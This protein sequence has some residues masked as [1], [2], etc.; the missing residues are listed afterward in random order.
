MVEDV[1][2]VGGGIAGLTAAAYLSQAGKKPLLLEKQDSCGGLINSFERDGFVYDGGIRATENSRILFPMLRQLG[3]DV[4]FANNPITLGIEDR[5][6]AIH[7]EEDIKDYQDLLEHIFPDNKA[8]VSEITDQMIKIM[9]YLDMQYSIENPAFL[10]PIKD[11]EYFVKKILPWMVKYAIAMPK[12]SRLNQPVELFLRKFTQ[13]QALIDIITQH[14]FTETPTYFALGYLKIYLD[15]YYPLGGTGVIPRKLEKFIRDNQGRIKTNTRIIALD[16]IEKSLVDQHGTIYEYQQ[17]IWAADLRTLYDL[18]DLEGFP[19]GK[20]KND[21]IDRKKEIGDKVG[22][23]S[24]LTVYLAVD[25]PP[26]YF[27]DIASGHFFYT[28]N[29]SGESAAG[30]IPLKGDRDTINEWL[31]IFFKQTTYEI[32]IPVL[33]DSKL[34]PPGKSGLIISVLFDYHLTSR[35]QDQGWYEEFKRLAERSMLDVLDTSIYPGLKNAVIHQFS[36]TPLT[37]EARTGN[38]HGAIT[39]WAFT[40]HPIPAEKRLLRIFGTTKTAVK[41]VVQAGQWTF[42]PSGLPISILT[43]KLAADQVIKT[44]K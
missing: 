15:Y 31:E 12:I 13:N 30:K 34:A 25:L 38:T 22:N 1:I 33:R 40:N 18:I 3:L 42:S 43:G 5:V 26:D 28:P 2:V 41:D 27:S 39:G 37:M 24:V 20:Q 6:I 16:P 9:A 8:E 19:E 17:L 21:L 44:L 14:F 7:S 23:N 11:R 4:E 32:S 29:R 35:I 36:S 10:D